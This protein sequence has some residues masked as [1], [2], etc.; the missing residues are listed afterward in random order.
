M[1]NMLFLWKGEHTDNS[2]EAQ[3]NHKITLPSPTTKPTNLS[4]YFCSKT[5]S[6]IF[7]VFLTTNS[8]ANFPAFPQW[9]ERTHPFLPWLYQPQLAL[10][11]LQ[12]NGSTLEAYTCLM[13]LSRG[14]T[15]VPPTNYSAHELIDSQWLTLCPLVLL[16]HENV[17]TPPSSQT[18]SWVGRR[19]QEQEEHSRGRDSGEGGRT[20]HSVTG[21]GRTVWS[22]RPACSRWRV[23]WD[24][25]HLGVLGQLIPHTLF[26]DETSTGRSSVPGGPQT[27]MYLDPAN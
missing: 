2:P 20:V 11:E 27:N 4:L 3:T 18:R 14:L 1:L 25:E 16:S 9:C 17:P 23:H 26:A 13:Y 6:A 15:N 7:E 5:H 8:M 24:R 12:R 22:Q 19:L 10:R 21:W